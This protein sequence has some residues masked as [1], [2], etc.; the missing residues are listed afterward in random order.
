[1]NFKRKALL[2]FADHIDFILPICLWIAFFG[3]VLLNW[4]TTA[5]MLSFVQSLIVFW[6]A[7]TM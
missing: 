6:K 5:Q 4:K 1:M 7:V 2:A 3:K